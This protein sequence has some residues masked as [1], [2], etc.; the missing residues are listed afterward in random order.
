MKVILLEDVAS[1]GE[2]GDVVT[3]KDGYARNLL[4]PKGLAHEATKA[5]LKAIEQQRE[6]IEKKKEEKRKALQS[7]SEN[8][9]G[10]ELVIV[11]KAGDEGRLFGTVTAADIADKIKE[12]LDLDIDKKH[13]VLGEHIKVV[14]VYDIAIKPAH[15]F[16]TT[17]K[18]TV[19][20]EE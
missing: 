19:E 7:L 13:I 6:K 20:P 9:Q 18:I 5:N 17:I 1:L 2:H 8:L 10:K 16:E 11:K 4:I 3:V 14:G 12:V 15:D